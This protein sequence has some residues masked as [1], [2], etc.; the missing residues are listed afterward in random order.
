MMDNKAKVL[1]FLFYDM[2]FEE[3]ACY[4]FDLSNA[5]VFV[6]HFVTKNVKY[7]AISASQRVSIFQHSS[8]EILLPMN[9]DWKYFFHQVSMLP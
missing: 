1:L 7:K 4:R 8:K 6:K 5:C 3:S 2:M 9:V